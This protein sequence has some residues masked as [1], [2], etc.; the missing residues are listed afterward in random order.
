MEALQNLE[1]GTRLN[2]SNG[3]RAIVLENPRDGAWLVVQPLT[4]GAKEAAPDANIEYCSF[5]DVA[6]VES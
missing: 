6:G 1:P 4:D 2:L 3:R 5:D